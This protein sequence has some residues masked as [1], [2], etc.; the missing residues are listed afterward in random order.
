VFDEFAGG[1]PDEGGCFHA[2]DILAWKIQ[3]T[4]NC[5]DILRG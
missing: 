4:G 2:P 5:G 3:S 1:F